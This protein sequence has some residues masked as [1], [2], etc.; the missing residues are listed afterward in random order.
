MTLY[1]LANHD[2]WWEVHDRDH[3]D[4]LFAIEV[5]GRYDIG[6]LVPVSINYRRGFYAMEVE[7][8]D[9][10]ALTSDT[11]DIRRFAVGVDTAIGI[12]T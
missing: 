6:E 1:R 11:V 4:S 8:A 3:A 5:D 2:A 7:D 9:I 10:E 12:R